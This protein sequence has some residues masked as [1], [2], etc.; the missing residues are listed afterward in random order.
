MKRG[1]PDH[2]KMLAL[3][4]ALQKAA[5]D[6][7]ALWDSDLFQT[8]AVGLLERLW[9]FTARYA[10]SGNVGKFSDTVIARRIGWKFDEIN[11]CALLRTERWLDAL[12]GGVLFVHDWHEHSDDAADKWLRDNGLR[13]ANGKQTRR[14]PKRV[15]RSRDI[16]PAETSQ[17]EPSSSSSSES[18]PKAEPIEYALVPAGFE[19]DEV[20]AALEAWARYYREKKGESFN[21][22]MKE[23]LM[24]HVRRLG[25]TP[26]QLVANISASIAGGW[27]NIRPADAP[28]VKGG[29]SDAVKRALEKTRDQ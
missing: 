17:S 21:G 27:Q 8:V 2:P 28:S 19:T 14:R 20:Q 15:R 16:D 13:Y 29:G 7:L 22:M 3:A 23:H 18:K 5:G 10:P 12:D 1:T 6:K 26:Q 11:L 24:M 9:H 25:W 4:E